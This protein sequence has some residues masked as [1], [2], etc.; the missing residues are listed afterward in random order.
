MHEYEAL[1]H[2][3]R[4]EKQHLPTSNYFIPHHC[5]LKPDSSTTKLRVVFDASAKT[6]TG[7]SLNDILHK[8]PTVQSELFSILLRFRL[9]KYVF[10]ADI[11]KMYRQILMH[12]ED[13]AYQLIVWRDNDSEEY[14]YY[15]LKTVTYG[16]TSAPYLATKCLQYLATQNTDKYPLGSE[17][18]HDDFYVDDC[19]SGAND[20]TTAQEMQRQVTTLL[21]DAGFKLRKWCANNSRLLSGIPPEDQEIN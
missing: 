19:L 16:T 15:R 2:M 18:V 10:T 11:E 1:G 12:D 21:D 9:H 6:S 14:R 5:V 7:L 20:I 17:V 4:I 3:Q 8:G 13:S